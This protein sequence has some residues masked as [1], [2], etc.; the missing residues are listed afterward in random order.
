MEHQA[1][2][3][4]DV[5]MELA[6]TDDLEE[7]CEV[8]TESE[9]ESCGSWRSTARAVQKVKIGADLDNVVNVYVDSDWAGCTRTRRSTNGG[10]IL[11]N[12]ACL[13][14]WSTTQTVVARY[15]ADVKGAA[16]GMSLQSMLADLGLKVTIEVHTDSS[17]C[18]RICNQSGKVHRTQ[19]ICCLQSTLPAQ[20]SPCTQAG[21]G[22]VPCVAEPLKST[23]LMLNFG[24]Q[25]VALPLGRG[26]CEP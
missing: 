6:C 8:T 1:D 11:L 4:G 3:D 10:C 17:A 12:G 22:F 18:R 24:G 21:W 23:R 9:Q 5:L 2:D 7:H 13:K 19:Q 14:T 16:E 25:S 15:Y 26:E 20:R